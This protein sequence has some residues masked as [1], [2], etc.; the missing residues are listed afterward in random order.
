MNY[1]DVRA[2]GRFEHF[3]LFPWVLEPFLY[4]DQKGLLAVLSEKVIGPAEAKEPTE[5]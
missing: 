3:R 4:E 2:Y 1:H 5:K